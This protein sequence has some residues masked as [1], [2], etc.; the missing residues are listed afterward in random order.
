MPD[1]KKKT[2]PSGRSAARQEPDEDSEYDADLLAEQIEAGYDIQSDA[3]VKSLVDDPAS[4]K[5]G[6]IFSE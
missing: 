3:A 6:E 1:P 4:S 2:V 5:D